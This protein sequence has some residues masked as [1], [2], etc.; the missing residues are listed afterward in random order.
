LGDE[1]SKALRILCDQIKVQSKEE[2]SIVEGESIHL[3]KEGVIKDIVEPM[4]LR[5]ARSMVSY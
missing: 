1:Y 5:S 4:E 3:K 2:K